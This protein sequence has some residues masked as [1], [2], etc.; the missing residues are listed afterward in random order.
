ME[1]LYLLADFKLIIL[2]LQIVLVMFM[3]FLVVK[4]ILMVVHQ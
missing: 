1:H 3:Q 2:Y 4:F